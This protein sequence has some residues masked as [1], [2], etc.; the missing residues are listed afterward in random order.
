MGMSHEG[1]RGHGG[2][3]WTGGAVLDAMTTNAEALVRVGVLKHLEQL[4]L[5]VDGVGN[6][7]CS[8]L[9][10]RV[11]MDAL[12]DF[13]ECQMHIHSGLRIETEMTD[14]RTW[15]ANFQRWKS[16][17]LQLPAPGGHPLVLVPSGW[18]R[19]NPLMTARRFHGVAV[20]GHVQE[21]EARIDPKTGRLMTISKE[22][23]KKRSD[24]ADIRDAN[25]R[26]TLEALSHNKFLLKSFE[27]YLAEWFRMQ[28][29]VA[30]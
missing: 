26:V 13:T 20:L 21:S 27:A 25:I 16:R 11:I 29:N 2:A 6:D 7:I 8:D 15:D 10:A 9:T 18:A 22:V 3:Q 19:A 5:F 4:P 30:A 28:D 1:F 23:L 17:R 12:L 14:I 24:L